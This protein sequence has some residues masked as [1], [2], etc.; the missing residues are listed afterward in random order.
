MQRNIIQIFIPTLLFVLSSWS[1]AIAESTPVAVGV[2]CGATFKP[3][4]SEVLGTSAK[5]TLRRLGTLVQ[6][7]E[8]HNLKIYQE[9]CPADDDQLIAECRAKSQE[10]AIAAAIQ[11]CRESA[12]EKGLDDSNYTCKKEAMCDEDDEGC[13]KRP[14]DS[15]CSVAYPQLE[16][17]CTVSKFFEND[18]EFGFPTDVGCGCECTCK[19]AGTATLEC[20]TCDESSDSSCWDGETAE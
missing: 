5:K 15:E 9:F 10:A 18:N 6:P 4:V 11:E 7:E 2:Q 17:S 1:S 13:V 19:A 8:A 16:C 14:L 20:T 3:Q 12:I